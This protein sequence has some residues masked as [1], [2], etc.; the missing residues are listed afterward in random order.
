MLITRIRCLLLAG[1]L[2]AGCLATGLW[3]VAQAP[4]MPTADS[5]PAL[6]LPWLL[7]WVGVVALAGLLVSGLG[8]VADAWRG[9]PPGSVRGPRRWAIV[10]CGAGLSGVLA[11]P[12]LAAPGIVASDPDWAAALSGLPLPDRPLSP[13]DPRTP[14]AERV[15]V[16]P[17][18]SLWRITAARLPRTAGAGRIAEGVDRLYR[19]N[20]DRIG[21]DPNLLRP[22]QVLRLPRG[23]R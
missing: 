12:A 22:G 5:E 7:G 16:R 21:P 20:R 2:L 4:P 1:A 6:A 14:V 13:R 3:L 9:L 11:G 8:G 18:D 15:R 10:L 17:G 19:L 23:P